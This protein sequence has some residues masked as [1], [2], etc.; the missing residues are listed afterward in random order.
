V[1]AG[2]SG[3]LDGITILDFTRALAGPYATFLLGGMGARIIRIEEPRGDGRESAP[4]Y[5]RDGA[6]LRRQHEDDVSIAHLIRHRGKESITLNL[7]HPEAKRIFQEIVPHVDVVVENFSRGTSERLGVGYSAARAVKPDIIY[8]SI[9]G[10]GQQ[11]TPGGG[12]AMDNIIQALSGMMM[13]SGMPEDPPARIAVPFGDL[14]TPLFAVIGILA[15]LVHRQ[16][17][18]EGQYIDVSMLGVLTSMLSTEPF[19]VLERLGVPMRTGPTVPRLAPFGVYPAA[20]GHVVICCAGERSFERFAPAIGHPELLEDPDYSSQSA[21][22]GNYEALDAIVGAWSR[23][24]TIAEVNAV[25][26]AAGIASAMVRGPA[27]AVRDP[28][29]LDRGEVIRLEHPIYGASDEVYGPG[30]PITFSA[31]PAR[32]ADASVP[33]RAHNQAVFGDM[34]GYSPEEIERLRTERAI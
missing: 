1:T 13:T 6:S 20:D 24:R 8:C 21:R 9:S 11:G 19:D 33:L 3:P 31:T 5:G 28:I 7:K 22:L 34:L 12:K 4:F 14:N 18:G 17:T 29:V 30:V 2:K 26:E 23:T 32:P 15:A 27:E 10:F 25:L 16:T